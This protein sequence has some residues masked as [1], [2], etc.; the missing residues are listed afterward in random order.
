MERR[1]M[2]RQRD[3]PPDVGPPSDRSTST[4][5]LDDPVGA[6][7]I[8][9][10][11]ESSRDRKPPRSLIKDRDLA[12]RAVLSIDG[13]TSVIAS[14]SP[15]PGWQAEFDDLYRAHWRRLFT[16]AHAATGT[17]DDAE[18]LAQTA[19][20]RYGVALAKGTTITSPSGL[21]NAI[22]NNVIAEFYRAK[23][24]NAGREPAEEDVP[25]YQV[26]WNEALLDDELAEA[27]RSLSPRQQEVIWLTIVEDLKPAEV[28]ARL[29]DVTPVRISNYKD[30][31]LNRLRAIL[32][33]GRNQAS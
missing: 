12:Q 30:K 16:R 8:S 27:L 21:L 28:S 20:A 2:G 19:F 9:T 25:P 3:T 10:V 15:L 17:A 24:R 6:D 33:Q 23:R 11:G 22:L 18:D 13:R 31:A 4:A 1:D 29:V 14:S 32:D 5:S 7:P 26:E